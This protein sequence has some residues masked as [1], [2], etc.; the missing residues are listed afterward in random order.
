MSPNIQ[1]GYRHQP[2]IKHDTAKRGVYPV[3]VLNRGT[4][5][6]KFRITVDPNQR[7]RENYSIL[8]G[9]LP[10][11][12]IQGFSAFDTDNQLPA[13]GFFVDDLLNGLGPDGTE[14]VLEIHKN[15]L[16]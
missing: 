3:P 10:A 14:E 2:G 4:F 6:V 13:H 12:H 5:T 15:N 11:T 8:F 1:L 16:S 9:I 7:G